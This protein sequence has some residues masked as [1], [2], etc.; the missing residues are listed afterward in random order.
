MKMVHTSGYV[1]TDRA[2]HFAKYDGDAS[3]VVWNAQDRKEPKELVTASYLPTLLKWL[4]IKH[5]ADTSRV[6]IATRNLRNY[7]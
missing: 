4:D 5:K 3:Y 1:V 7:K 6:D 2:D